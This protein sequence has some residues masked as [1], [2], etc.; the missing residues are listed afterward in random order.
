M[1]LC[2][3]GVHFTPLITFVMHDKCEWELLYSWVFLFFFFKSINNMTW[4]CMWLCLNVHR[5]Y[6]TVAVKLNYIQYVLCF[7]YAASELPTQRHQK[8]WKK[9]WSRK[10]Q[11]CLHT[12]IHVYY[13]RFSLFIF[14]L[15]CLCWSLNVSV[16]SFSKATGCCNHFD[17]IDIIGE[18]YHWRHEFTYNTNTNY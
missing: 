16:F 17:L 1:L 9:L 6:S 5:L 2:T 4:L 3:P 14:L 12:E 7:M 18:L 8:S 11:M 15:V 13:N 10:K